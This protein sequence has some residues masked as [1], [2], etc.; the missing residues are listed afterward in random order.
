MKYDK[1]SQRIKNKNKYFIKKKEN[2]NL[3]N[4]NNNILNNKNTFKKKSFKKF[5]R[6]KI[7]KSDKKFANNIN[8]DSSENKNGDKNNLFNYK[9]KITITKENVKKKVYFVL[10]VLKSIGYIKMHKDIIEYVGIRKNYKALNAKQGCLKKNIIN[11]KLITKK[12]VFN[13][14]YTINEKKHNKKNNQLL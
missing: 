6:I 5:K 12:K 3:I 4:K 1:Y 10:R 8:K 14:I 11:N 9:D 13:V 2:L 7:I